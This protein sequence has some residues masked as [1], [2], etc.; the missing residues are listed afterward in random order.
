MQ[1]NMSFVGP[2]A[3]PELF[4]EVALYLCPGRSTSFVQMV[5]IS[6]L[7]RQESSLVYW[8]QT[9]NKLTGVE[10]VETGVPEENFL[11][12]IMLGP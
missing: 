8:A 2:L 4:L 10:S 7:V 9:Q 6:T 11:G 3:M 12:G 5:S 1:P